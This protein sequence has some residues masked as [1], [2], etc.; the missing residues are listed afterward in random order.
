MSV[1]TSGRLAHMDVVGF[2]ESEWCVKSSRGPDQALALLY[3]YCILLAKVQASPDS[4][5]EEIVAAFNG[6]SWKPKGMSI[7]RH[8]K[9]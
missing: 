3:F 4:D 5:N 8:G 2:P 6:R 9:T 1:S 7:G